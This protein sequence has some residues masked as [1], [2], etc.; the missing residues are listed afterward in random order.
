MVGRT[1]RS[2]SSAYV[3][4]AWAYLPVCIGELGTQAAPAPTTHP[5]IW[6]GRAAGCSDSLPGEIE[7]DSDGGWRARRRPPLV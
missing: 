4:R 3:R 6:V 5:E 1:S 7:S 2:V